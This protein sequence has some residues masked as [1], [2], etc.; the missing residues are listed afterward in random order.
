M[1][2]IQT[3]VTNTCRFDTCQESVDLQRARELNLRLTIPALKPDDL[4][5]TV[6]VTKQRASRKKRNTLTRD[7]YSRFGISETFDDFVSQDRC[8]SKW[9]WNESTGTQEI[10]HIKINAWRGFEMSETSSSGKC[11]WRRVTVE[12]SGYEYDGLDDS[13]DRHMWAC[14]DLWISVRSGTPR[15]ARTRTCWTFLMLLHSGHIIAWYSRHD[16]DILLHTDVL[17]PSRIA[18]RNSHPCAQRTLH[19]FASFLSCKTPNTQNGHMPP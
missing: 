12:I 15:D 14:V 17:V 19:P 1:L 3:C 2:V 8:E 18:W 10:P 9:H 6:V 7:S 11:Q 16:G 4:N 5:K 13:N